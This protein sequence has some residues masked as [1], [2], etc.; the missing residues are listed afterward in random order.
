MKYKVVA[1]FIELHSGTLTLTK[2]QAGVRMH[3]LRKT[4]A[5][6]EIVRPVQ[7]KH[8]EQIGY[9]GELTH[10]LAEAF[11]SEK[12]KEKNPSEQSVQTSALDQLGDKSDD[13]SGEDPAPEGAR[14]LHQSK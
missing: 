2:E 10:M 7:F 4:K 3:N 12:R 13:E 8:G 11:G 6:Y 9:D 1:P 14:L 5:G